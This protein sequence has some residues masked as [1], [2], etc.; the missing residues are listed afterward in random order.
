MS[1]NQYWLNGATPTGFAANDNVS[2]T[3]NPATTATI[4]VPANLAAGS[5]T[6]D[7]T[8]GTYSIGGA[9]AISG[10]SLN[11]TGAGILALTSNNVFSASN[12]SGGGKIIASSASA[13]GAGTLTVGTGGGTIET[14]TDLTTGGLSGAGTLTKIGAGTLGLSGTGTGT[15][16]IQVDA[17]K[18]RLDSATALGNDADV[19]LTNNTTLEYNGPA[20]SNL[21]FNSPT[22]TRVLATGANNVTI[23]NTV[24]ASNVALIFDATDGITGSGTITK[25]GVGVVRITKAHAGLTANWVVNAGVL[26]TT[27]ANSALGSGTVTVNPAGIL[28]ANSI[29]LQNNVILA[30][31]ALGTRTNSTAN[32]AG[33]VNVTADSSINLKSSSTP[34]GFQGFGITGVLS[35]AGKL[36][37]TGAVPLIANA[38]AATALTLSNLLNSYSGTINITSQTFVANAVTAGT[39]SALGTGTINLQ[40]GTFRALDNSTGD[41]TTVVYGNNVTVSAP[42][43]AGA[44]AGVGTIHVERQAVPGTAVNN[45]IQLGT[46]AIAGGQALGVTGANG[47]AARFSGA[48]TISTPGDVTID[49]S[50]A[51]LTLAGG[52]SGTGGLIKTGAATLTIGTAASHTGNTTVNGGILDVASVGTFTVGAGQTLSGTGTVTGNISISGGTV[53]PG[54]GTGV[55]TLTVSNLTLG[56][57]AIQYSWNT[58]TVGQVVVSTA[59]ALIPTGAANSVTLNFLGQNPNIGLHT[60]IDYSGTPLTNPQFLTFAQGAMFSR[61]QASLVNNMVDTKL[62]LNVTGINYPIWSGSVSTE[63]SLNTIGGTK[64]WTLSGGG[65]PTDFIANDRVVFDNSATNAAPIVDIS[66]ANVSPVSVEVTGSKNYTFNGTAGIAG[67]TTLLNNGTGTLTINNSNSFTGAVTLNAG[68]T[69]VATV[70]DS[71]ANSPL[72]AGTTINLDTTGT[73][74]FTGATGS[75]N[76]AL[77]V[78]AGGGAVSAP[79]GSTLT[80]AGVVSGAGTLE[81]KGLGTVVLTGATNTPT[82]LTISAGTL[83]IGDGVAAGSLGATPITNNG[84]LAFNTIAAGLAVPNVISGGGAVTKTGAGNVTLSGAAANTYTGD[85]TVNGGGL[86]LSHTSGVN[87]IGGNLIVNVGATVAYG[88]TAGQLADHISD[89]ATVTING[90]TFGSGA[91]AT[92]AAP[93]EGV[94]D[95]VATLNLNGGTF[96]SGRN[97]TAPV[98]PFTITGALTA[99]DGS[100]LLQRGG[101]VTAGSVALSGPTVLNF[102]GGTNAGASIL[103]VGA[104]GIS[105]AGTNINMNAGPSAVVAASAGSVL[106]LGGNLTSSGATTFNRISVEAAPRANIDLNGG[107]RIFNITGTLTLGTP[108]AQVNVVNTGATPGG[109]IKAGTGNLVLAGTNTYNG[110]TIIQNGTVTL[111]GSLSGTTSIDVQTSTSF[112]VSGAAGGY[113]LGATQTLKGNGTITGNSTINGT[114]AP[115]ASIGTLNFLNDV[116][117]G[118]G[119][120]ASYEINKTGLT[121]TA[122]LANITGALTLAGTLNVAATGDTLIEGDT[123]NLFDAATF[124]G[125]MTAGTMPTLT[126]GLFWKLTNL[127]VDGSISVVPEPGSTALLVLGSTLLFRR[128]RKA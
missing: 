50:T 65:G 58:G 122:D 110:D 14:S 12:L 92:L 18:L 124:A 61:I 47:Y 113:I 84:T 22:V 109:L 114:L 44:L 125:T 105:F 74:H 7:H 80:L 9:G 54:N 16:L 95:T 38:N 69:S 32:F 94:T 123:F 40:G 85:T 100:I 63:W 67:A 3:D 31:G 42:S 108:A 45:T 97:T 37:T 60:L 33:T 117:F 106:S 91:G 25:E 98:G 23:G 26:E 2:F 119:G 88:T 79:T 59:D 70:A 111:T 82:A 126:S 89:G 5:V 11:K 127:G 66:V 41:N 1:G 104:G 27:G 93:T 39:G 30:G 87:S 48:A 121:L 107:A 78:G 17:G 29:N 72:G 90:G 52:F 86:V 21:T 68:T 81:K 115:G 8:S 19:N 73:L 75:T 128:R 118:A 43:G 102:D 101:R 120:F 96:L 56:T 112:N 6:V 10:S 76:R 83:Q 28:V 36:T 15:G 24:A 4:T 77:T 46:L 116:T 20:A 35:G 51:N 34:T 13:L 49:T 53:A 99:T 71:G 55:G 103:N 62:E 57:S 64:N